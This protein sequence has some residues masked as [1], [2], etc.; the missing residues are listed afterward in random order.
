MA[1]RQSSIGHRQSAI[2]NRQ[3]AG[4]QAFSL[5]EL[6]T[7]ISIIG[8]LLAI[9]VG[10]SGIAGRKMRESRLRAEL[11]AYATAIESYKAAFGH[12]PPDN[13]RN[14][15]NVNPAVNQLYYELVGTISTNR[16]QSYRTADRQTWT[17]TETF[18]QTFNVQG[19]VNSVQWPTTR[20]RSFLPSVK[21][22]QRKEVKLSHQ[23]NAVEI[24]VTAVDWP[25][26]WANNPAF[27]PPYD[28]D[29]KLKGVNPWR[30]VSTHPTNNPEG[31]DLWAEFVV[32]NQWRVIGNWKE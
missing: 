16:G 29:P 2:G 31:F 13:N 3:F 8:I 9:G 28:K 14:G 15:T 19:I 24:L 18:Q 25:T 12:Y 17:D 4:R 20:P 7:V 26:K 30:Y 23:A 5:I 11:N 6:L 21:Q 32:G 1:N 10:A 22:E 27:S